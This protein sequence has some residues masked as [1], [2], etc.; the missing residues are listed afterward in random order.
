LQTA[1]KLKFGNKVGVAAER[2]EIQLQQSLLS[3]GGFGD[4]GKHASGDPRCGR[5]SFADDHD[6]IEA[7]LPESPSD[8]GAD[9]TT[10]DH[11]DVG[12]RG[13]PDG[14]HRDSLVWSCSCNSALSSGVTG[15][16]GT[17]NHIG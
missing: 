4:R 12:G 5:S 11:D 3:E 1:G 2:G 16:H 6:D 7:S 9:E 10:A 15:S 8:R 17:W 14:A 13:D